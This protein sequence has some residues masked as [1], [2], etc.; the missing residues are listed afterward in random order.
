TPKTFDLILSIINQN[1]AVTK[2]EISNQ[3]NISIDGVKYHI[4]KLKKEKGL[5]WKGPSKGGRWEIR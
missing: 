4:R 3:L 5:A 2:E 1:P